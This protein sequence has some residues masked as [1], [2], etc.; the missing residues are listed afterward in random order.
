MIRLHCLWT[1]SNNRTRGQR[2]CD[3]LGFAF[4]LISFIYMH[5]A[6]GFPYFVEEGEGKVRLNVQG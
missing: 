1:K 6:V 2:E 4:A 5:G 3:V